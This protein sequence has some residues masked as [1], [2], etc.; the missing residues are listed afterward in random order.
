MAWGI[1]G[2]HDRRLEHLPVVQPDLEHNAADSTQLGI[3][4]ADV[5][6]KIRI[7][8]AEVE[9]DVGRRV[10]P[11]SEGVSPFEQFQ[12]GQSEGPVEPEGSVLF[13]RGGL[14]F[15]QP[16]ERPGARD[17]PLVFEFFSA[18]PVGLVDRIAG[19]AGG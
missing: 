12:R 15:T 3:V 10:R 16:N 9:T 6:L 1:P 7:G 14:Q 17:S 18:V 11:Q 5:R 19:A 8:A 4:H 13:H 2:V